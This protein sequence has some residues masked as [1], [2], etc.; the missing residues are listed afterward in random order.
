MPSGKGGPRTDILAGPT[1][2]GLDNLDFEAL[3]TGK[4][5][6][7]GDSVKSD[8]ENTLDG[9][10]SG[11]TEFGDQV[12]SLP[13][14]LLINPAINGTETIEQAGEL[15][16]VGSGEQTGSALPLNPVTDTAQVDSLS[17][18]VSLNDNTH[19]IRV[20]PVE[21]FT[22]ENTEVLSTDSDS[23]PKSLFDNAKAS[24]VYLRRS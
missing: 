11:I 9:L 12:E 6:S 16:N 3:L 23:I 1:A 21:L 2:E 8:A 18:V 10:D 14:A 17:E 20:V 15:A 4:A 7:L 22:D 24:N 19:E 13:T 5:G